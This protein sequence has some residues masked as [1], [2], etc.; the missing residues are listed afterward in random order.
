MKMKRAL[1]LILSSVMICSA[2]PGEVLAAEDTVEEITMD[3]DEMSETASE[4]EEEL[5]Y[6]ENVTNISNDIDLSLADGTKHSSKGRA[7]GSVI[8]HGN[9]NNQISWVLY[10]DGNLVISGNGNT[11]NYGR[12]VMPPW[13]KYCKKIKHVTLERGITSIG[14]STFADCSNLT[15]ISIP[16]GVTSIGAWAFESCSSLLNI[17]IPST[18]IFVDNSAFWGCT[19]LK[20][21]IYLGTEENWEQ[22]N[23]TLNENTKVYYSSDH[24]HSWE[25]K[26]IKEATVFSAKQQVFVCSVCGAE[27][28]RS[29][30]DKLKATIKV[31]ASKIEMKPQEKITSLKVSFAN[32]DAVS[33]WKIANTELVKV[34]GKSNGTC[35]LTAGKTGGTTTLTIKLKS[36]LTKKVSITVKSNVRTNVKTQKITGVSSKITLVKG[37]Y[38]TIKPKLYPSTSTDKITYKSNNGV[39]AVNSN[40]KI[41]ARKKGTAIITVKA[42][43]KSV[44]SQITVED[45]KL[46]KT[47]LSLNVGKK[48]TLKVTGTKQK[49]TWS[50]SNKSVATVNS[51][52]VVTARRAGSSKITAK[53]LGKNYVCTVTVKSNNVLTVSQSKLTISEKATI[54]IVSKTGD[55]IR[56][57]TGKNNV[58]ACKWGKWG[59]R[60]EKGYPISLY[61]TAETIGSDTITIIEEKTGQKIRIPVT[62]KK[63]SKSSYSDEEKM[64]GYAMGFMLDYFKDVSSLRLT[65]VGYLINNYGKPVVCVDYKAKNS[66]GNYVYKNFTVGIED[67]LNNTSHGFQISVSDW[68][69]KYLVIVRNSSPRYRECTEMLDV[70][71]IVDFIN[72]Y[73]NIYYYND[74]VLTPYYPAFWVED[75]YYS[76]EL[77]F[78]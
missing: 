22:F 64:A 70:T 55:S 29:I 37:Q 47:S 65:N 66:Y 63:V 49:I 60:T 36:G 20:S 52:G 61:I 67:D 8:E 56:W 40:G 50:S 31:S 1:A 45:P 16:E 9:V 27:E 30:G 75:D 57:E 74:Q 38:I 68:P 17:T 46:S 35:V 59:T 3:T 72:Q 58:V 34:S 76:N 32:G 21:V 53:V 19:G 73:G 54:K 33:S 25:T 71:R 4:T 39:V 41:Y 18:T 78:R 13:Y 23:V 15:S 6:Q 48:Y 26:T 62:V 14:D 24:T 69:N 77:D 11:I 51:N 42:G 44:K 28:T 10:N 5:D 7:T 12:N 43:S 2:V